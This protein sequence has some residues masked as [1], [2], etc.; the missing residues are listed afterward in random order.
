[1]VT[2]SKLK[3][4]LVADKGTD[5]KKLNQKKRQKA[6]RKEK[7]LKGGEGKPKKV[8][9]EWE[10]LDEESEGEDGREEID[11]EESES[12]SEEEVEAPMQVKP[13]TF[14]LRNDF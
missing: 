4:A 8:E 14:D 1:M 7:S 13:A 6:A 3:M 12:G 11:G 5:F 9:E 10:D 2:K